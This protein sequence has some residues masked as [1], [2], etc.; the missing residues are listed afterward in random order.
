VDRLHG[1]I[2]AALKQPD[3]QARLAEEG[4]IPVGNSPEAFAA[5]ISAEIRKWSAVVRESKASAD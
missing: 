1:A 2:S 4:T 5:Y 3:V